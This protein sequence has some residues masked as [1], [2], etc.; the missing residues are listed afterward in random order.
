MA[1]AEATPPTDSSHPLYRYNRL[2]SP[3]ASR[4]VAVAVTEMQPQP[5]GD[6]DNAEQLRSLQ[7]QQGA[8]REQPAALD[9]PI[10]WASVRPEVIEACSM[11]LRR[12]GE[13]ASRSVAVT[14][15]ARREGRTTVAVGLAT[16][17]ASHHHRST[18]LLELDVERGCIGT[19]SSLKASPGVTE[20]LHGDAS[21]QECLKR[22][23]DRLAIVTAGAPCQLD[24]IVKGSGRLYDLI[25]QLRDHCEV[26]IAD[27]PPLSSGVIAARMADFFES[28]ALVVRAGRVSVPQIEKSV[29]VL[30]QRPFVILN[31]ETMTRVARVR[32]TVGRIRS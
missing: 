2:A 30:N 25:E 27:L 4:S 29:S 21:L 32:R 7:S 8:L 31:A 28:V 10:S 14:S 19:Q 1:S 20:F 5:D 24:E 13:E 26:L 15:A 9:I 3:T 16:A 18:I 22:T 17:S 11:S 12:M 6:S 23:G